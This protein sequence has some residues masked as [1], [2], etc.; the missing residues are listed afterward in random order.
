MQVQQD[1]ATPTKLRGGTSAIAHIDELGYLGQ[2]PAEHGVG[3]GIEAPSEMMSP[4]QLTAVEAHI[5]TKMLEQNGWAILDELFRTT[6]EAIGHTKFYVLPT[7]VSL[8]K[9]KEA[10]GEHG[11]SFVTMFTELQGDIETISQTLL[12]LRKEH[13][14]KVHLPTADEF[15]TISNLADA[16]NN[17]MHQLDLVVGQKVLDQLAILDVV[18]LGSDHLAEVYMELASQVATV[19]SAE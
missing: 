7:L 15:V 17:L 8:P 4:E 10:L 1:I 16:Y 18:G 12:S 14:G 5:A 9:I 13:A 6:G 3:E 2:P 19:G 11:E